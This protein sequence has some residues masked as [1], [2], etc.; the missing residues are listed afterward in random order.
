M[1][2]LEEQQEYIKFGEPAHYIKREII[3]KL[4]LSSEDLKYSELKPGDM[5]G[6]AFNH[7]LKSLVNSE[8]VEKID[9]GEYRLTAKGK[10]E[11]DFYS[12]DNSRIKIRPISGV[13]LLIFSAD[14][15]ILVY[16]NKGVPINGVEG[17][18]F[19][20]IR[21]GRSYLKTV[22][23]MLSTRNLEAQKAEALSS[24]NI[25]YSHDGELV[26]HRTGPLLKI[27]LKLNASEYLDFGHSNPKICWK[28]VEDISGD[29]L[30]E[31]LKLNSTEAKTS[32]KDLEIEV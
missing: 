25:R 32:F 10:R 29:E 17:M 31:A 14:G 28:N 21:L 24:L 6:N 26:A 9:L 11:V 22:A 15:K 23:R 27:K 20:K 16:K 2:E 7:H 30:L 12:L 18:M 4:K 3:I 1:K 19:G 8:I 13:Y 5:D